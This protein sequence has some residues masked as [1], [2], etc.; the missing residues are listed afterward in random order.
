MPC[1]QEKLLSFVIY[2]CEKQMSAQ[3][4]TSI[5]SEFVG[6]KR[7]T[8]SHDLRT[9]K[10]K[11]LSN[12]LGFWESY[13]SCCV[14]KS[15]G[16]MPA[17]ISSFPSHVERFHLAP[18]LSSDRWLKQAWGLDLRVLGGEADS[19]LKKLFKRLLRQKILRMCVYV[20]IYVYTCT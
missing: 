1:F 4:K 10:K 8:V 11:T 20:F 18:I 15:S 16:L 13:A 12:F 6:W 17:K 3:A 19:H 9:L 7:F 2:C 14:S 5:W